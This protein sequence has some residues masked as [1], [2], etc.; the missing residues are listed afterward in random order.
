MSYERSTAHI[1]ISAMILPIG[2]QRGDAAYLPYSR[3]SSVRSLMPSVSAAALR[4]RPHVVRQARSVSGVMLDPFNIRRG[5][6]AVVNALGAVKVSGE[7]G[8]HEVGGFHLV[9]QCL[10]RGFAGVGSATERFAGPVHAGILPS[11]TAHQNFGRF[12][13]SGSVARKIE[14]NGVVATDVLDALDVYKNGHG[15]RPHLQG[16]RINLGFGHCNVGN[17]K[18]NRFFA[19]SDHGVEVIG[20]TCIGSDGQSALRANDGGFRISDIFASIVGKVAEGFDL[21]FDARLNLLVNPL[22]HHRIPRFR[23]ALCRPDIQTLRAARIDVNGNYAMRVN[24]S[25]SNTPGAVACS[26]PWLR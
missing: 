4:D 7:N 20:H 2:P 17:A 9:D 25:A 23:P 24:Y 16:E 21:L 12:Q 22:C 11:S 1:G 6:N 18:A 15:L 14:T 5:D 19:F 13:V 3:P 26:H 8:E 10:K